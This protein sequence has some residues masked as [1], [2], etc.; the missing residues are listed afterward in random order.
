MRPEWPAVPGR[1]A[2]KAP[3]GV[4]AAET[5]LEQAKITPEL[6]ARLME[7]DVTLN[8]KY[9]EG[10]RLQQG[11]AAA[12]AEE[13]RVRAPYRERIARIRATAQPGTEAY[14]LQDIPM[15]CL[16]QLFCFS[17]T[18]HRQAALDPS[19]PVS[20]LFYWDGDKTS[21]YNRMRQS[22]TYH[23]NTNTYRNFPNYKDEDDGG[24]NCRS[25]A[26][27]VYMGN[28]GGS[29]Y[30]L[31]GEAGLQKQEDRCNLESRDH[32]RIFGTVYH[33][34]YQYWTVGAPHHERW[35]VGGHTIDN[36]DAS[37]NLFA[38]GW[39]EH[40]YYN[41]FY[42]YDPYV[43]WS[44]RTISFENAGWYQGVYHDNGGFVIGWNAP[45]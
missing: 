35:G 7:E 16:Y 32:M 14:A 33:S 8:R 9:L 10:I 2:P 45:P 36:W 12:A 3:P 28:Y 19:D 11:P 13:E 21:T 25:S 18:T 24:F 34:T 37:R 17:K 5:R 30:W 26:Q 27:W 31:Q 38:A 23:P 29:R 20:M 40:G 43:F 41:D 4:A 6:L 22:H 44:D 39:L 42:G 15:T 1:P